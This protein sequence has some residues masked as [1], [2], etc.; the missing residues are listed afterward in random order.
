MGI[1]DTFYFDDDQYRSENK[2]RS[3]SDLVKEHQICTAGITSNTAGY[4]LGLGHTVAHCLV[5]F[6]ITASIGIAHTGYH[7]RRVIV[8]AQQQDIIESILRERGHDA[9]RTRK[10]DIAK[11]LTPIPNSILE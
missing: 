5:T 8:Y 7:A 3:T 1:S 4:A 11:G 10:R 6:G 9:P 2:H